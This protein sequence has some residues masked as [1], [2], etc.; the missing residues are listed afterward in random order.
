MLQRFLRT[1][2]SSFL[3]LSLLSTVLAAEPSGEAKGQGQSLGQMLGLP[4]GQIPT[5]MDAA[6][7]PAPPPQPLPMLP[8]SQTIGAKPV[9]F[10]SQ[11]FS[12]RFASQGFSGFNP[13]YQVASGDRIT[14]RMWGL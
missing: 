9:V 5:T 4:S 12:G 14:L 6:M 8:G 7:V 1:L 10:G 2:A 11:I 13:D 3:L